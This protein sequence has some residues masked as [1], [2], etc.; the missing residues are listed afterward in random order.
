MKSLWKSLLLMVSLIMILA[1]CQNNKSNTNDNDNKNNQTENTEDQSSTSNVRSE[2]MIGDWSGSIKIPENPLPIFISFENAD[3]IKGD[4]SIPVQGLENHPFSSIEFSGDHVTLTMQ[5]Q[6]QAIIFNGEVT[7]ASIEGT[8]TQQGQSFPFILARDTARDKED[9]GEFLEIETET[10]TLDG[11]LHMPEGTESAPIMLIIPGSG[12]TDRNGN[13]AAGKNNSLKFL[14]EALGDQ[15]IASLR[16]D[17]RGAGKNSDTIGDEADFRF[18]QYV[19][20]AVDWVDLLQADERFES[21]GII[22]HSEGSLVGILTAKETN[23]DELISLAGAGRS[24]E[25]TLLDQIEAAQLPDDLLEEG[26]TIIEHLKQGEEVADVSEALY[27]LFRPSV[28]PY[29][30]SWMRYNPA[31]EIKKLDNPILIVNGEHDIQVPVA[32]AEILAEAKPDAELL[33]IEDMNHVLKEA[34]AD[35][36]ENIE[37]YSNPRLPLADGLM[38]GIIDFLNQ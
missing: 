8:F 12:D 14:A 16:F 9:A 36:T 38:D 2:Q 19:E 35:R 37:T 5:L 20:D 10:G 32:E 27:S 17:K 31:E 30:I 3:D 28:Q 6:G 11:E 33:I 22:G 4:M 34:P 29:M 24:I 7:E 23:I 1:G 25:K 18:G 13:T 26:Q 21:V 15:G